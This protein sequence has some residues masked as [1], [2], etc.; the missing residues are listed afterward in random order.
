MDKEN[1]NGPFLRR[2]A[3][4]Q[5]IGDHGGDRVFLIGINKPPLIVKLD[6]PQLAPISEFNHGMQRVRAREAPDFPY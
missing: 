3:G 5:F 1:N 2:G 4:G 6:K